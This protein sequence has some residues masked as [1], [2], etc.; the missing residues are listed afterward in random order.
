MARFPSKVQARMMMGAT[1]T[2]AARLLHKAAG[3]EDFLSVRY[4]AAL[5]E[6]APAREASE[7]RSTANRTRTG[8]RGSGAVRLRA[9]TSM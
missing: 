1:A 9:G 5:Q 7:T 3:I 2:H 4:L 6:Y 8:Y